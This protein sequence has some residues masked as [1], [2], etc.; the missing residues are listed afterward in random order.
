MTPF[1]EFH[2]RTAT[3]FGIHNFTVDVHPKDFGYPPWSSP[4]PWNQIKA[5]REEQRQFIEQ[6]IREK[7]ERDRKESAS[8]D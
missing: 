1:K 7:L 6:A 3:L 8:R 5:R 4:T 2:V